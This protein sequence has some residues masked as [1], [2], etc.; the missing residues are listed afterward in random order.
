M[1]LLCSKYSKLRLGRDH[2]KP[3]FSDVTYFTML[4]ACG[5]GIGIFY[6]GVAE[7]IQHYEPGEYGNRY[8]D[9]FVYTVLGHWLFG[10]AVNCKDAINLHLC[11]FYFIFQTKFYLF[12]YFIFQ[13][14]FHCL[15]Y[16][17]FQINFYEFWF[18]SL[19]KAP[20]VPGLE[21]QLQMGFRES[22]TDI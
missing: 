10:G 11:T 7:T 20:S 17:I 22:E 8:W 9:R 13:I 4:F 15:I 12:I 16:F 3:E 19:P 6:F 2:E 1:V 14:K 21:F 5:I 18:I